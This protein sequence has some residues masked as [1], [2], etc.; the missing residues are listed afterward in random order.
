MWKTAFKKFEVIWPAMWYGQFYLPQILLRPFLKT[1]IYWFFNSIN[2][3]KH[4]RLTNCINSQL[5]N[6]C[7]VSVVNFPLDCLC[8]FGS[9]GWHSEAVVQ[10]CSVKKVFLE[11]SLNSQISPETCNFIKKRDSRTVVFLWILRNFLEHLFLH[12]WWLLLDIVDH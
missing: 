2:L 12:L 1:S 11:I 4:V 9:F 3:N 6:V 7:F 5:P 10:R 8:V